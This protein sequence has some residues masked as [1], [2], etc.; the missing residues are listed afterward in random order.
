MAQNGVFVPPDTPLTGPDFEFFQGRDSPQ[1]KNGGRR[2]ENLP[3]LKVV[4]PSLPQSNF[5]KNSI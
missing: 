5:P 2:G 4:T 1:M 3:P